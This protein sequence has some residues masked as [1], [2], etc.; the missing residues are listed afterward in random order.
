MKRRRIFEQ[1]GLTLIEIIISFA[2]MAILIIAL[3]PMFTTAFKGV[4]RAGSTSDIIYKS[5]NETEDK[6]LDGA[7]SSVSI[8]K[9]IFPDTTPI[10]VVVNGEDVSNGNI[11]LFIPE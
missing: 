8:L 9:I 1:D 6:I 10:E 5:Q 2:F 4:V 7:A 3:L 11:N